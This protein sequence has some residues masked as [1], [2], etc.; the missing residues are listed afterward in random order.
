VRF[1]RIDVASMLSR[2]G[3]GFLALCLL[4]LPNL[5]RADPVPD[6]SAIK[7]MDENRVDLMGGTIY[8]PSLEQ[9]IG[10][11]ESGLHLSQ[12]SPIL[13]NTY[14]EI[15][16]VD[17]YTVSLKYRTFTPSPY[18]DQSDHMEVN[19]GGGINRFSLSANGDWVPYKGGK[20][21]F[22]CTSTTCTYTD[23]QG[24]VLEFSGKPG[25]NQTVWA[26]RLTK[27]DGEIITFTGGTVSSSLGWMIKRR[28]LVNNGFY[29]Q[30]FYRMINSAA[31]YCDP[32]AD[33]CDTLTVYPEF[34]PFRDVLGNNWSF[35]YVGTE[36]SPKT[37]GA[38]GTADVYKAVDPRGVETVWGRNRTYN[39]GP[40]ANEATDPA[41]FVDRVWRVTRAGQTWTYKANYILPNEP[42]TY[43]G[44]WREVVNPPGGGVHILEFSS[45]Y[46]KASL[47]VNELGW[48]T[49]QEY[50][51][52]DVSSVTSPSSV[53]AHYERDSRGNVTSTSVRPKDGA[54]DGSQDLV[55]TF[56]FPTTCTNVKT[57]NKP[58][59]VTDARGNTTTYTYDPNHG[60]VLTETKPAVNGVQAQTRYAYQ[61]FT[62]YL[63]TSTGGLAPQPPV[64]RLVSTSTCRT[65]TLATCVGTEDELKTTI[66][67]DP[68]SSVY[69]A[70]NL[71]PLSRT[72]S[73]GDGLS[74]STV[75]FTYD[76]YGN[77][78][79]ED[80]PMPGTNDAVYYFYDLKRQRIG[81]I[82]GDP[83]GSG[84][85]PRQAIRTVY[86]ADG[87]VESVAKGTVN[88]TTLAALQAMV[89][90]ER[91]DTEY[92][93]VTGL[94][95]VER[96]YAAGASPVAVKQ[97]SYDIR[98]RLECVAQRMN[99][100]AFGSLPASACSLG[101]A[102]TDGEDRITKT[103]Y[104]AAGQ[105]IQVRQ[106]VGTSLE[107]AYSTVAY[108]RSGKVTDSIDAN[109]NLSHNV[110]D[111]F[112]RL[113]TYYYPSTTRPTAFNAST[114][115]TALS[116]AGAYNAADY[117]AFTYDN[118][119]NR[120]TTRRRD[121]QILTDC[122][123]ALNR[124]IVHYVHSQSGC[125]ATG[126]AKDVY[127]TY[128]LQGHILTKRFASTSGSGVSYAYDG[129]GRVAS[130]TDMFNRTVSYQYNQA[131]ARTR[132]TDNEGYYVAYALDN[133]NRLTQ[134]TLNGTTNVL[135]GQTFNSLGQRTLL[136]R[137][138]SSAGGATTYAYDNLSRLQGIAIDTAGTSYDVTWGKVGAVGSV[139]YNPAGQITN[140]ASSNT[141]FNYAEIAGTTDA[142]TYDGLNRDVGVAALTGGYDARGNLTTD[143][144]RTFTYDVE[145]RLL[146]STGGTNPLTLVYD[147]EGR[148][149]R[150]TSGSTTK[151]FLYDGVDL[152]AEYNSN[153]TVAAR[154]IHGPGTDDPLVWLQGADDSDRRYYYTNYQGSLIGYTGPTGS[155][156]TSS[157]TKYGAYGEPRNSNNVESWPASRFGYTGQMVLADARL[158]Y[159]KA[160]VYDPV[161]GRFLQTDPIGSKDDL[162]LYAYVGGDPVNKTDPTGM[163][164][165]TKQ[166]EALQRLQ[167]IRQQQQ[168]SQNADGIAGGALRGALSRVPILG[169][170]V[171][172]AWPT[173][174]A[175]KYQD[176]PAGNYRVNLDNNALIPLVENPG[177]EAATSARGVIGDR[178]MVLSPQVVQEF[179]VKGDAGALVNFV[180]SN[181]VML[182]PEPNPAGVSGLMSMGLHPEDARV[183]QSGIDVGATTLTRDNNILKKVPII[184][185]R[186]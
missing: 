147:P 101:T 109:G 4:A 37:G 70:R 164:Q 135:Y 27:P 156:V 146:T 1:K 72:V 139:A 16:P 150:V 148:L 31:D 87:Q 9:S 64:W 149:A 127:T 186:F 88:A 71:L 69:G 152:I 48:P 13:D 90:T 46:S 81:S 113:I 124:Q 54:A 28:G 78:I 3:L 140:W 175:S 62:P 77:V 116:T 53:A 47:Y 126:G 163:L 155:F 85:L 60:G 176:E 92:S 167:E 83:D 104:D 157:L 102:G 38:Y 137:G 75:S 76:R 41:W 39:G 174:L 141:I 18:G 42:L 51:G 40:P 183:V 36:P 34:S 130:S 180:T 61:Q 35:S 59:S 115:A 74:T 44:P 50:T 112:D 33:N 173:P 7:V 68:S 118:N 49:T 132:L 172:A 2:L 94:A 65:M 129:L 123:D 111:G 93:S 58:T 110:Y 19:F 143:G 79:V 134:A 73:S 171:A 184:S 120:L 20:G 30:G 119:G 108:A 158:Y 45:H 24:S 181:K 15:P 154:Y 25:P 80:G 182:A 153:G 86:G 11:S 160:R 117:E 177:G 128:D 170:A 56:V 99:P 29:I 57:C 107:R 138:A 12:R 26:T 125:T 63:K 121:G 106:G 168:A 162:D 105:V 5:V 55:T 136:S 98:G 161:F 100:G 21:D 95:M 32:A 179:M 142:R 144:T 178:Q 6:V 114:Q 159:Y 43:L 103:V 169:V 151:D 23:P 91:I 10:T 66:T 96:H 17:N 52:Y 145:N 122:Y 14:I 84:S 185:E 165:D 97:M 133:L 67:Y 8:F 82:G 22:S 89:P 166:A 131:G